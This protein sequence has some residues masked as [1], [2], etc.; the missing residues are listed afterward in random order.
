MKPRCVLAAI[1][2]VA[3]V[4]GAGPVRAGDGGG[5]GSPLSS[6]AYVV[7]F[8]AERS[9]VMLS[10]SQRARSGDEAEVCVHA[11]RSAVVR[12]ILT[13]R[14]EYGCNPFKGY[15]FDLLHRSAFARGTV[16][17]SVGIERYR[18]SHGK[19]ILIDRSSRSSRT[20]LDLTWKATSDPQPG[21]RLKPGRPGICY[22]LPPVCLNLEAGAWVSWQTVV[23]GT[24]RFR[25]IGL[26]VRVP[27]RHPGR[28]DAYL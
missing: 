5:I 1:L 6:A 16:E 12:T 24:I 27:A 17:T 25:G 14:E 21:A 4:S 13:V 28:I 8:R 26:D 23:Q 9:M 20:R 7:P 11:Y 22:A 19:W 3:A 10:V 15:G 18:R 2:A